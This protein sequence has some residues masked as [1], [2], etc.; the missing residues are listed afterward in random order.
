MERIKLSKCEKNA[1]RILS[2]SSGWPVDTY[3]FHKF[4]LG[5]EG[6]EQKGLARAAW[7][8]GHELVDAALTSRGEQYFALN[9]RLTNP[10]DWKLITALVSAAAT[11]AALFVACSVR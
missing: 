1:I 9:P 11:I 2:T 8:S 7:A 10:I 5:V 4:A 6:L 3:P